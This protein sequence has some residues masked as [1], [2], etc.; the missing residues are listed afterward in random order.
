MLGIYCPFDAYKKCRA[1]VPELLVEFVKLRQLGSD[2][3]QRAA[4]KNTEWYENLGPKP[5]FAPISFAC[6]YL[7][8][9]RDKAAAERLLKRVLAACLKAPRKIVTD[10]LRRYSAANA[11]IPELINVKHVFAKASARGNN[12]AENSHSLRAN[13]WVACAFS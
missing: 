11:E 7:T 5:H 6:D 4:I 3:L 8:R 10:Q 2:R 1:N 12:R 9:N 13:A